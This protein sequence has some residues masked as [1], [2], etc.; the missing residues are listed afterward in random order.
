MKHGVVKQNLPAALRQPRKTLRPEDQ[1]GQEL[2]LH[3]PARRGGGHRPGRRRRGRR[4][5]APGAQAHAR[6]PLGLLPP[7]LPQVVIAHRGQ[8]RIGLLGHARPS[9]RSAAGEVRQPRQPRL[10]HRPRL[11]LH[12]AGEG[13]GPFPGQQAVR[14]LPLGQVEKARPVLRRKHRQHPLQR[15]PR[16]LAAGA[17]AVEAEHRLRMQ[18]QNLA[19]LPLADGRAQG[20]NRHRQAVRVAGQHV[21]VAF[22]HQKLLALA[23]LVAVLEQ[24]VEQRGLVEPR[25]LGRVQVFRLAR[26]HQPAAEA[27]HL[28]A[29]VANREHH[30]APEAVGI[31]A[32]AAK[33]QPHGL[34][35]R[36][37]A[38][39]A[40]EDALHE[41]IARRREAQPPV[42]DDARIQPALAKVVPRRLALGRAQGLL[43]GPRRAVE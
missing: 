16:R 14:V 7:D 21:H 28:P 9:F 1:R 26:A 2:L 22:H 8:H 31:A 13:L 34:Q 17:V 42:A 6:G 36:Q 15:P 24:A 40:A 43:E 41:T 32:L 18:A 37:R 25:R 23:N 11:L 5:A 12:P 33:H 39:V 19:D 20:R 3:G 30:P 10:Q 29:P 38:A 4:G 27:H 35:L